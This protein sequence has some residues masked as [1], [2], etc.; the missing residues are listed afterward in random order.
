MRSPQNPE[1]LRAAAARYRLRH[2]DR[3]K[4]SQRRY[5][6]KAYQDNPG[7]YKARAKA[8]A[9]A[10]K[11]KIA[12]YEK[13]RR[14]KTVEE[15]KLYAKKYYLANSEKLK[16]RAREQGPIWAKANKGRVTARANRHRIAKQRATPAWADLDAIV[17]I[18]EQAAAL[19]TAT[20]NPYHVDHIVPLQG[21]I[22]A[23]LHVAN[24]LQILPGKENQSKG[25]RYWPDMP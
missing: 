7:K 15:R 18:Y 8:Y 22:V 25:A 16:R 6:Q 23:G 10:N 14:G 1:A 21:K 5:N 13:E 3:A 11:E 20:G 12:A 24:N 17:A 4:E 9:A 2:P 19:S